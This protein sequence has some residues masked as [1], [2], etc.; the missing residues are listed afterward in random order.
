MCFH[1]FQVFQ[2]VRISWEHQFS[3]YFLPTIIAS[4]FS[5]LSTLAAM[6][7]SSGADHDPDEYDRL[8]VPKAIMGCKWR[9]WRI[10][11]I[12]AIL[13]YFGKEHIFQSRKVELMGLLH[14][15][16]MEQQMSWGMKRMDLIREAHQSR[17]PK[18]DTRRICE[19]CTDDMVAKNTPGRNV[20]LSCTTHDIIICS[21]CLQTHIAFDLDRKRVDEIRCPIG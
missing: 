10:N 16:L 1:S 11:D 19:I 5:S 15:V 14:E 17:K 3:K 18:A 9:T 12:I 20:T 2:S 6:G 4:S 13:D 8:G 7:G 21:K